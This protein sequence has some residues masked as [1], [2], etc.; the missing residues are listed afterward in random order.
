MICI[1]PS[2]AFIINCGNADQWDLGGFSARDI[3]TLLTNKLLN[4]S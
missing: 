2:Y 1:L 4:Q 3:R